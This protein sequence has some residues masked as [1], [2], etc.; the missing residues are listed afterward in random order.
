LGGYRYLPGSPAYVEYNG[1]VYRATV[2]NAGDIRDALPSGV[3]RI[4]SD[5]LA[6]EE[7]AAGL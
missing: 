5:F 2:Y 4:A 6:Q 1:T 7:Q 3:N